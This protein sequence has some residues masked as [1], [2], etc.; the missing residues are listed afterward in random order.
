MTI[1]ESLTEIVL[2]SNVSIEMIVMMILDAAMIPTIYMPVSVEPIMIV[3]TELY[4][5]SPEILQV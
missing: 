1:I 4:F 5:N 2:S 3:I